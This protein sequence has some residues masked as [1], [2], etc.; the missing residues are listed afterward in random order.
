MGEM[1]TG[2]TRQP[3]KGT[4]IVG[5]RLRYMHITGHSKYSG[6]EFCKKNSNDC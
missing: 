4:S 5:L 3:S 1:R 2:E 6:I